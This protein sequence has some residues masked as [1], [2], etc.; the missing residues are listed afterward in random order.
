[1]FWGFERVTGEIPLCLLIRDETGTTH[2]DIIRTH[3]QLQHEREM[4]RFGPRYGIYAWKL[5]VD[6]GWPIRMD[7]DKEKNLDPNVYTRP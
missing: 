2:A 4:V 5:T 1:M 7:V 6:N 3:Q